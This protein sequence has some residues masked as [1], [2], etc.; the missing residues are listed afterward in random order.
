MLATAPHILPEPVS[1]QD[2]T[3]GGHRKRKTTG[4][5]LSQWTWLTY[6]VF[7]KLCFPK[8]RAPVGF[9]G[10]PLPREAGKVIKS[11]TTKGEQMVLWNQDTAAV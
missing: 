4:L 11:S 2:L 7:W 5:S 1:R 10:F 9:Q 6:S 3:L 8:L